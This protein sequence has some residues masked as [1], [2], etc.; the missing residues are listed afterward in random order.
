MNKDLD[1]CGLGNA[2]VDLQCEVSDSEFKKLGFE[3]GS[4]NLIDL[5]KQKKIMSALKDK[6]FNRCS[7]G[8]AANTIIAYSQF[9]GKAAYKT[10]LGKDEFGDFYANEFKELGIELSAE[11]LNTAPTGTC[12]VLITPDS[13]RT[14]LTFLGATS[15]FAEDNVDE[16]VIARSEWLYV[17][18]YKFSEESGTKAVYKAVELAKKHK[19]K[20]AVT[21]SDGFITDIFH[22]QLEHVVNNA[23]LIFCNETEAMSYTKTENM[24]EAFG[25][26]SGICPNLAV[27]KGA[28]GSLIKWDG[29]KYEI[30]VYPA[31][32]KDT[33]GAGD[34][35]AAGFFYGI[36]KTSS[37]E[38]AGSLGAIA[39]AK[40][41]SQL[42]AR[43]SLESRDEIIKLWE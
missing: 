10:I 26:L 42:G 18:G 34:M 27:T 31:N 19:T 11:Q 35:Y 40:V 8:S 7:G 22:S 9:G 4:M 38:K 25:K 39:S 15:N 33:T 13:E 30:P 32:L 14:M 1:L 3:R 5:D 6:K 23:D 28:D 20:I 12:L 43:L 29:K 2:L 36:V 41:V 21:F 24:N 17:E 16:E 37:P